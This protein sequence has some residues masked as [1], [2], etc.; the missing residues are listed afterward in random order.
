MPDRVGRQPLGF[1]AQTVLQCDIL[2]E[3]VHIV[4]GREQEQV[5][6]LVQ[7]NGLSKLV[8]KSLQHADGLDRQSDVDLGSEL[9]AYAAGTLARRALAEHAAALEEQNVGLTSGSQVIG[10]ADA[11]HPTAHNHD[12]GVR[13][14]ILGNHVRSVRANSFT[15]CASRAGSSSAAKW[16]PR[17]ATLQ[18]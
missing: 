9:M 1:D 16:P 7:P 15:S 6:A 10:Q 14:Q 17:G 2:A 18:R 12:F 13:R 8:F 11:H 4:V 5:P 3:G